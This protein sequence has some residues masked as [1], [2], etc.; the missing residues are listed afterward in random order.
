M[1]DNFLKPTIM[2]FAGPNGSG[3]ST[4]TKYVEVIPPYINADDVKRSNQGSDLEAAVKAEE[5]RE[6]A[7]SENSNFTFETVLSTG[8][9]LNLLKKAKK[10]GYFINCIYI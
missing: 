7:L 10:Q 1:P 5:L 2:V 9:N 8:R 4:I 6:K 3:K